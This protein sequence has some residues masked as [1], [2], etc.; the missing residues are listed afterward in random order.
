M[1]LIK[2]NSGIDIYTMNPNKCKWLKISS[3]DHCNKNCRGNY[4]YKHNQY[5]TNPPKPCKKCDCGTQSTVQLC[6]KCGPHKELVQR[7]RL[8]QSASQKS[9][10]KQ[11]SAQERK[12]VH[13]PLSILCTEYKDPQDLAYEAYAMRMYDEYKEDIRQL[14]AKY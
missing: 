14:Q 12:K 7:A 2:H 11:S 10:A 13:T 3:L 5:S 6:V 9:S 4:C 8:A 1:M